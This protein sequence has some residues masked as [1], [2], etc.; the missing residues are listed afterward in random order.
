MEL[1]IGDDEVGEGGN[2]VRETE[3]F[4]TRGVGEM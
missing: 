1:S 3:K 2:G 4:E